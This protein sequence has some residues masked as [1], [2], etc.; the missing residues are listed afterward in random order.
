MCAKILIKKC[1][2][3]YFEDLDKEIT[4]SKEKR[5]YL[6]DLSKDFSTSKG[7]I[8]AEDLKKSNGD[9]VIS[10]KGEELFIFDSAFID[11]YKKMKRLPQII[12][13]KDIGFILAQTG[14]GKDSIVVDAGSG[15]GALSLFLARHVKKVTTYEIEPDHLAVV[16]E[17]IKILDIK[18]IDVKNQSIYDG[19]EEKNVDLLTLDLPEPWLVL[20]HASKM[21]KPGGFVVSYSP[22]ITQTAE[23]VNE[24]PNHENLI[25]LKTIELIE[26]EW[27]V[28]GRKVRPKSRQIIHSG[29][30]SF[31]RKIGK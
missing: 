6:S 9:K 14:V 31:V 12:P 10:S 18:N 22:T 19:F 24:I 23:F 17:N 26:R 11:D 28:E 27:Q 21:L 29:F 3:K 15:S 20:K 16:K 8:K 1:I 4:L 2:K 30:L 25:H 5:Y 7:F 13:L